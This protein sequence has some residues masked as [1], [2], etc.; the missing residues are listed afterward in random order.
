M[1]DALRDFSQWLPPE[2]VK[3]I[4]VL[5]LSFLVG[6]EREE[7]RGTGGY[8]FGGVRT[9][10]LIGLIGYAVAF[11]SGGELLPVTLGFAVVGGFLMLSFHHKLASNQAPGVT[12]EM[13]GLVIYLVGV[14]VYREQFWLATAVCVASTLLLELKTYLE[15]LTTRIEPGEILTFTKFL[16]VTAVILPV[17]PNREFGPFAINPFKT[18]LVVVAVSTVSYASYV[19]SRVTKEKEKGGVVLAAILGGAY[20]STVATVVLA[21]RAK[22]EKHPHLFSGATL[23]ACGMMYLRLTALLALFNRGLLFSLGPAFVALSVTAM[24][25]GWFWSRRKD[26]AAEEVKREYEPKNPL[27][28]RSAL[29]FAVLFLAM[30]IATHFVAARLGSAG[31]Y[32][33][34]AVLGVA[35]V[36][37]FIMGMTQSTSG[38]ASLAVAAAGIVIAASSNN[39]AKGV[40]AYMLS[41]RKTG[42]MS[43]SLLA[44]LG[45]VG[46][47][48]LI[49][50]L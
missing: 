18:W 12:S 2:G 13:S 30:L 37:P 25:L 48:P 50:V 34:A 15:K 10:P 46:L 33:L 24:A 1:P 28:L 23:I 47:A 35:D 19:I 16:L 5:F 7:H 49:W 21:R 29:V 4:L 11:L 14:L 17:L 9:F 42:V 8:A 26:A 32:A 31:I 3:I 40:Y 36:D 6:L 38:V 41:D 44:G 43:L 27:E 39:V 45:I 22:R 20:S